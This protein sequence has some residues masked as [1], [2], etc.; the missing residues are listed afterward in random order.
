MTKKRYFFKP[1]LTFA[2]LGI[3]MMLSKLLEDDMNMTSMIL[4][5]LIA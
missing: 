3:K 1:K 2:E 5:Y 4:V